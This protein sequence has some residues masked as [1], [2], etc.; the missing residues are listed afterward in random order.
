MVPHGII[1]E[2]EEASQLETGPDSEE[3]TMG[4]NR[5]QLTKIIETEH[6]NNWWKPE[7]FDLY[8]KSLLPSELK[9]AADPPKQDENYNC[10]VY[11][12]GL[13]KDSEFLGG[14]NPVQQEF[15][16]WLISTSILVPKN[17]AGIGDLVFYKNEQE[18]ITHGGIMQSANT[19]I[20]KWM[21]GPTIVHK[22][23]DVPSSFGNK[24]FFSKS[25]GTQEIK[26]QYL[27]YK[28]TGV[29]IKPIG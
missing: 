14:K 8:T 20:S 29:E 1:S 26:S 4:I 3:Y 18:E 25:P 7:L 28:S 23:M 24:F 13:Q 16:K 19:V 6:G 11:A 5:Q 9:I 27:A 21:W 22:I 17:S 12:F 2:T 15:V 10:F